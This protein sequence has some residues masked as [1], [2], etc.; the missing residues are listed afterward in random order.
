M[1]EQNKTFRKENQMTQKECYTLFSF[2][3]IFTKLKQKK[4]KTRKRYKRMML[5]ILQDYANHADH[6]YKYTRSSISITKSHWIS[7]R[8]K[9]KKTLQANYRMQ[10]AFSVKREE[11]GLS[12]ER[13]D[14]R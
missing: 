8:T 6:S 14:R 2:F 10:C 1:M 7:E 4:K 11:R 12:K 3:F 9:A 5:Q 13:R